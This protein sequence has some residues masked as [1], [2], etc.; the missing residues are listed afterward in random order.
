MPSHYANCWTLQH[1][2]PRFGVR[3]ALKLHFVA[4][5]PIGAGFL[6]QTKPPHK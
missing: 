1:A 2:A 4:P 6:L 3:K 5:N